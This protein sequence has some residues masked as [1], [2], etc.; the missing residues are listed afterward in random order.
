MIWDGAR[1]HDSAPHWLVDVLCLLF[2][3]VIIVAF[4]TLI[5]LVTE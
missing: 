2:V 4:W 1:N 3:A 5:W